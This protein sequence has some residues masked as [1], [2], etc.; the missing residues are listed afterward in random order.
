MKFNKF[1]LAIA[2][3]AIAFAFFACSNDP[4][5]EP[6]INASSS[7]GDN[8]ASSSSG[9]AGASSSSG[10]SNLD[11]NG[12]VDVSPQLYIFELSEEEF[13]PYT[14]S[15]VLKSIIRDYSE[16][17]ADED[18]YKMIVEVGTVTNGKV[19]LELYTPKEEYLNEEGEHKLFEL[20]LYDNSDEAIGRLLLF[21][22]YNPDDVFFAFYVYSSKDVVYRDTW[23]LFPNQN[24]VFVTD[25]EFKKGWNMLYENDKY[26]YI[27]GERTYT[28]TRTTD[29]SIL[30][31]KE[32]RWYLFDPSI[33]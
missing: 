1:L 21:N 13:V 28:L 19:N 22:G 14:G 9:N 15:G 30:K 3:V 24:V 29:P 5:D 12:A 2:F 27:N 6:S 10:S 20:M 17:E 18:E 16:T 33:L 32:L 26:D 25:I 8:N 7:S 11:V 23:D 31:G 4:L